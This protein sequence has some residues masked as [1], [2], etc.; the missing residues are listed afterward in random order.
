MDQEAITDIN[1]TPLVDVALVLVIIFMA[2]SPFMLQAGIV[3]SESKAGAAT[4]K[5]SLD[6]NVQVLLS[7]EGKIHVNGAPT[8]LDELPR[9]LKDALAKSKDGL[10]T[11]QAETNNRVGQVVEI[12]DLA[13]QSGA[14]K[15]AILN[16][17]EDKNE[18]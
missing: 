2:V 1:V 8:S 10:V 9:A 11:L 3:V 13:K 18:K 16:K 17:T 5:A 4:G 7:A 12:L 15:V 6:Q 14:K